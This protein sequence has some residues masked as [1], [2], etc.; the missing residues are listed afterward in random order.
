MIM[1]MIYQAVRQKEETIIRSIHFSLL[2]VKIKEKILVK[3][4]S[5]SKCSKNYMCEQNKVD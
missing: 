1:I 3:G 4:V 2:V 5:R